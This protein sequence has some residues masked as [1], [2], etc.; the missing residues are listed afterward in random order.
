M[1][2]FKSYF[3]ETHQ[4]STLA[5]PWPGSCSGTLCAN[6]THKLQ[7]SAPLKTLNFVGFVCLPTQMVKSALAV[8]KST[9]SSVH[10][11]FFHCGQM[12][13]WIG[14]RPWRE[15][16]LDD[17]LV[18]LFWYVIRY[19]DKFARQILLYRPQYFHCFSK[20]SNRK[21]VHFDHPVVGRNVGSTDAA[22]LRPLT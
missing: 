18:I 12:N 13:T 11:E 2:D 8:R 6:F 14:H 15:T 3:T 19:H 4:I 16:N 21:G 17:F 10:S 5:K 22:G 9:C 20:F 7:S 1:L